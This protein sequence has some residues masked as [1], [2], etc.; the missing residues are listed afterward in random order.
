MAFFQALDDIGWRIHETLAWVKDVFVLGYSD[1]HYRHEAILYGPGGP[2]EGHT[3]A[4]GGP[5]TT[6]RTRC[7]R[8]H[9]RRALR[10]TRR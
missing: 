7:S 10:S 2:A 5:V 8:S 4:H 9:G 3:R 1:Y 6:R